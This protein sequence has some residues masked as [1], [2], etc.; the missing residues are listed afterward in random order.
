MNGSAA[1]EATVGSNAMDQVAAALARHRPT[2]LHESLPRAA[3]LLALSDQ[4]PMRMLLTRR[5]S[6]LSSHAGQVAFPGGRRD[7]EDRHDEAT[8]LREAEEEV[9]LDPAR[10][11]T[12]GR[13]SEVVSSN[14]LAVTPVVAGI[15]P[16]QNLRANPDEIARIFHVPVLDLLAESPDH[17]H[18]LRRGT[19]TWYV[20]AWHWGG[21]LIWGLTSMILVEFFNLAF[22]WD[23]DMRHAPDDIPVRPVP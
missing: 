11:R 9:G 6:A 18:A 21:E 14:G 2:L 13:L 5:A 16:D 10:V 22:E 3:V 17:V 20:P 19:S 8:A 1:N 23:F 4:G 15:A 12:L 7:P